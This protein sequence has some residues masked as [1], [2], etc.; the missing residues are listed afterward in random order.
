MA[1]KRCNSFGYTPCVTRT[2]I[3]YIYIYIYRERERE[4]CRH[5][6]LYLPIS[7]ILSPNDDTTSVYQK[8]L[9]VVSL[10]GDFEQAQ[11]QMKA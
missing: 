6:I 10:K 8:K 5:P 9:G 1:Q 3:I 4:R 7:G 11:T 2:H